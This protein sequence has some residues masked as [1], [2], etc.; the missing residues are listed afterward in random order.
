MRFVINNKEYKFHL[1]GNV[2][3]SDIAA[4]LPL[5]LRAH[6]KSG[7]KHYADLPFTPTKASLTATK[8]NAGHLYYWPGGNA[9]VVNFKD[10]D[11][12][13]YKEVHIGEIT[14]PSVSEVLQKSGAS[15]SVE[16]R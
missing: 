10:F 3:A 14:D 16:I 9:F 4:K 5:K 15:V 1:N 13:P 7:H 6:R 12:Y 2:T 8:L 11:T